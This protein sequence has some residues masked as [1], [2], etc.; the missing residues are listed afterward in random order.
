MTFGSDVNIPSFLEMEASGQ[1]QCAV[2]FFNDFYFF[3]YSWFHGVQFFTPRIFSVSGV[4]L[5][6][7]S[8]HLT[9]QVLLI[10]N[11]VFTAHV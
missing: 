4:P 3:H 2:L 5:G 11:L 1:P 8:P 7:M 10:S 9:F 6:P